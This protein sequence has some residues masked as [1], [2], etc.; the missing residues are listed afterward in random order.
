MKEG[1]T[2][3]ISNN[4]LA[5]YMNHWF[6]VGETCIFIA[7]DQHGIRWQVSQ[8]VVGVI[9]WIERCRKADGYS[10]MCSRVSS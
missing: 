2:M 10:V 1:E 3:D 7:T 5:V 4:G 6:T 9:C 8:K